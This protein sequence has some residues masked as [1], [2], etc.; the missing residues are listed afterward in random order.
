MT[1]KIMGQNVKVVVLENLNLIA[2]SLSIL[3]VDDIDALL[4]IDGKVQD[5]GEA[6]FNADPDVYTV[7]TPR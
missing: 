5:V 4:R 3:K 7:Y 2:S 6:I 1:V